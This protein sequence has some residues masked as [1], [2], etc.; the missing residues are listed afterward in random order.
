MDA[1]KENKKFGLS[2]E[3]RTTTRAIHI[4]IEDKE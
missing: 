3:R 4:M 2:H 1:I